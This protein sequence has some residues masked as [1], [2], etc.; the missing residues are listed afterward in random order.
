MTVLLLI[1]GLRPWSLTFFYISYLHFYQTGTPDLPQYTKQYS[2]IENTKLNKLVE[3]RIIYKNL[4]WLQF[5]V[6]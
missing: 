5:M 4:D 2:F 6:Q 1:V 3:L